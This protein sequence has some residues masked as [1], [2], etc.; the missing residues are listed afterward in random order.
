MSDTDTKPSMPAE[1]TRKAPR[2]MKITLALSLA[3]NLLVAGVVIGAIA[4]GGPGG[5]RIAAV[6]DLGRTPFVIA[7]DPKDR[8]AVA[9]ALRAEGE[10][11]L[12]NRRELKERFEEVLTLLRAETFDRAAV[13]ALIAEQ[14]EFAVG[15]QVMGE[16]VVL[17]RL[18]EMS[19]ADRR[20]YADRLDKSM[21]RER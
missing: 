2:W 7:L 12:A 9:R 15:R 14:R 3:V 10:G 8:R 6:R 19:V 18:S 21:R 17:D 11:F 13:E 4:A 20:A 1:P 5:E 16:R